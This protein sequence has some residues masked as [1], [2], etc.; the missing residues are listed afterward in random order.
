MVVSNNGDKTTVLWLVS[1][2][3]LLDNLIN[4]SVD[5]LLGERNPCLTFVRIHHGAGLIYQDDKVAWCRGTPLHFVCSH[6]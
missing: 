6:R 5:C 1:V 3:I 4:N 2:E